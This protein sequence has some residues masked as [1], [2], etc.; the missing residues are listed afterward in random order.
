M[1]TEDIAK[2][3]TSSAQGE[4]IDARSGKDEHQ[5]R[6]AA[7]STNR[8][9][10]PGLARKASTRPDPTPA[11]D[12]T[13]PVLP[14][15]ARTAPAPASGSTRS[16][17]LNSLIG[18]TN[19]LALKR[20]HIVKSVAFISNKGGVGKTH[21]SANMAFYLGRIGKKSLLIDLD[22]GNSDVTNKLGFFCDNTIVDL[23][24]GQRAVSQLVYS[25]PYGFD[26]IGGEAG[27]LRLANMNS[28]QRSRFIKAFNE[29][30]RDYDFIM[31]DLSAG[32][33]TI[34]LDFALAQDYQIIITTPQDIVAGYACIKAAFNRFC[35]L[36]DSMKERNPDY[37]PQKVFRPFIVVN[38]VDDFR[39]GRDLFQRMK[40]VVRQN[41]AVHPRYGIQT[42][43]L[44]AVVSDQE[45]IRESELNRRLYCSDYGASQ[46][47]QCFNF[48]SHNLAKY[49][50]PNDI[51]FTNKLRRFIDIFM[52]SVG[53][54]KYAQ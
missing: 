30:G 33:N 12:M 17:E 25:A 45:R 43:F 26:V 51:T 15:K 31:Y 2:K 29:L 3:Q 53:E 52:K 6:K 24:H 46:T 20:K 32:I 4:R 5:I 48:L 35:E 39:S 9:Q 49:R 22:L 21:I 41:L 16:Q 11:P 14:H 1:P 47:G 7:A 13:E 37:Q 10:S 40:E 44:G 54:T 8:I 38:Q 34:T 27:D 36:E 28:M 42:L 18:Q 23:L 19:R 50:D